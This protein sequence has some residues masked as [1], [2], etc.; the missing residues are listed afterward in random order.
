MF[1]LI[2]GLILFLGAHS[3]RIWGEDFRERLIAERGEGVWKGIYSLASILGFLLIVWGYGMARQAPVVIWDPPVWTRHVGILLNAAAFA[4]VALNGSRGPVRAAVGHPMVLGV[5]VWAF[6]HLLANGTLADI[7]LF[8]SFLVW[9]IADY[10]AARRRDRRAGVVRMAGPWRP[11][12]I[13]M[14][15]GLALWLAFLLFL[16]KWLIGVSPLG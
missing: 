5:K 14:G 10:A 8:G 1:V 2:L 4:L 13:R 3:V 12:L 6:A 15:I 7:F 16:H 11:E 9:A